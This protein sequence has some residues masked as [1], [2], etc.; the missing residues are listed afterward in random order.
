MAVGDTVAKDQ[1][2]VVLEAMKMESPV[3]APVA[4]VVKAVKAEQGTLANAGGLLV[5]LEELQ[6]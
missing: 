2:L 5:V 6:Q 3:L 4:A 1:V